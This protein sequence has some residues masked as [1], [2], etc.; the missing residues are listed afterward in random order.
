MTTQIHTL[1]IGLALTAYIA[2]AIVVARHRIGTRLRVLFA[3]AT[4]VFVVLSILYG[5][6]F[7]FNG[8]G[9]DRAVV[10]HLTTGLEGAGFR[11]FAWL[12]ALSSLVLAAGLGVPLYATMRRHDSAR[13]VRLHTE[14][15]SLALLAFSVTAHPATLDLYTLFAP[16]RG[17][18]EIRFDLAYRP[19]AP[20]TASGR[21]LNLVLIYLESFERA[22]LDAPALRD[23]APGLRQ[24][25]DEA[26]SFTEIN[27][28][29]G[30]GWTIAGM[31]TS[32]CGLPLEIP[33]TWGNI[34]E[35]ASFLPNATCMGDLLKGAGYHLAYL[36][37]ASLTFGNKGMFYRT[38][39]YDEVLGR[40]D[41]EGRLADHDYQSSWGLYDDTTLDIAYQKYLE[42]SQ[43]EE[44][45]A[46]SMVTVDTHMPE[47]H[48][49]ASCGD[50]RFTG[51]DSAM[52]DA[53]HCSDALVSAFVRK[54]R[55]SPSADNTLVVLAS[56]HLGFY[57][58][59]YKHV[60]HEKRRIL[61]LAL[62]PGAAPGR[63]VGRPGS[64]MDI[65]V[66]TLRLMGF[67][68]G[69]LGLGRDLL[70]DAATL[71]EMSADPDALVTAW[72]PKSAAFW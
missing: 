68:V 36:G 19:P 14:L 12:I 28:Y 1:A 16:S 15:V 20:I 8:R 18:T 7:Y 37:G 63:K 45:F 34:F 67:D 66:T 51:A 5:V 52:L 32:Q 30:G 6:A 26:L 42:L 47:G 58:E 3:L 71:P 40:E 33:K 27:Q 13:R 48:L 2:A 35:A 38:H 64:Q 21:P 62:P 39:G 11:D 43:R 60:M 54:I 55:Q 24:L 9:V 41:L 59:A 72:L 53:V 61:F 4:V 31:V 57:H 70:G 69:S 44:P 29:E 49:S 25:E 46:L 23:L 10:Y 50:R 22:Y 56:D 17:E 65:G